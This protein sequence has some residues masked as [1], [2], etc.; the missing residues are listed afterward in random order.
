MSR[1]L[2]V[3]L[4][5]MAGLPGSA[6]AAITG[7]QEGVVTSTQPITDGVRVTASCPA[8]KKVFGARPQLVPAT[9]GDLEFF[10]QVLIDD[11]RPS[12]DLTQLVVQAIEDE[13]GTD[14]NWIL[15]PHAICADPVAGLER[16]A[17]TSSQDSSNKSFTVSCPPG[18]RLLGPGA[19]VNAGQ[20]EV[21]MD[22]LR[23]DAALN[24]VFVQGV[25]DGTGT[26]AT[27]SLTAYAICAD[28]VAGLERVAAGSSLDS[29]FGKSATASCSGGKRVVG[30]GG[31]VAAGNGQVVISAMYPARTFPENDAVTVLGT[32]DDD[33]TSATWGV[34]AYAICAPV[35]KLVSTTGHLD[36]ESSK[37]VSTECGFDGSRLTGVGGEI[38]GG[39]GQVVTADLAPQFGDLRSATVFGLEDEN[40]ITSG[41]RLIAYAICASPPPG[42]E[43]VVAASPINSQNKSV[44]VSCSPGKRVLGAGGDINGSG[45]QV[46]LDDILPDPALTKVTAQAVEDENGTTAGWDIRANALC[47]DPVPGL[48]RIA[49]TSAL[50]SSD[51]GVSAACPAGKQL[52]GTGGQI[53]A[54][55][56]Q[57]V[58]NGIRPNAA[59]T[60]V[61]V[62]GL[63]DENGVMSPWSLTAYAI[64]GNP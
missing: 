6:S 43:R 54:G 18:K 59:L 15:K 7:L 36:S 32:E 64:C 52:L 29:E 14:A 28:P 41:W 50:D 62:E 34:T 35:L 47:S 25:E 42:L 22:D 38:V 10:G 27:W 4:V 44:T 19:D 17:A 33:G 48:Q 55:N 9:P 31:D 37:R 45:G 2:G 30:A 60:S 39:L 5:A 63:E 11:I 40:G 53:N 24:S 12:A 23:P 21:V 16:V 46:L 1:L 51:K 8:G 58:L 20:G 13:D 57:V 3:W 26:S 56:G 61:R 49:A